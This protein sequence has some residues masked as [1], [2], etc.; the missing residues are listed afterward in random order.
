[1]NN[2]RQPWQPASNKT[3][4]GAVC[5]AAPYCNQFYQA[6]ARKLWETHI[7]PLGTSAEPVV[8]SMCE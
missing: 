7:F 5:G 1:M 3:N 6:T 2:D 4:Q 8:S